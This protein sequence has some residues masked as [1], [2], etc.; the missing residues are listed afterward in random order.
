[1]RT[2]LLAELYQSDRA[3]QGHVPNFARAFS[4]RPEVY[5]AWK[6]LNAAIKADMD[7]RTYELATLAA[8][9][10][11]RSSYCMLAHGTILADRFLAPDDVRALAAEDDGAALERVTARSW[12]S[13]PRSWTT[14]RPSPRTTSTACARWG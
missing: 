13:P 3:L 12:V 6:Q 14:P 1:M 9:R 2:G 5:G 7:L 10:R 8:A 11:L 4:L